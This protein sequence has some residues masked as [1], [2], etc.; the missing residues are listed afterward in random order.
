MLT[1][2]QI[3]ARDGKLTAS[4]VACLMTGDPEKIMA[5]WLEM[6]GERQP[7][8]LSAVWPVQLGVA[9]EALNLEWYERSV[10]RKLTRRGEVVVHPE[11][12]WACSTLD[13]FDGGLVGPVDAK[14][15]GGFEPRATVVARYVPQMFWQM[16][17]T[18]TKA[19]ALSIIE[20]AR[21]PA[22]E[23]VAWDADYSTEL[24]KRA[25]AF[26]A[27][28]WSLTPPV[29]LP[30]AAVPVKAERIVDMAGNNEFASHAAEW[31][32]T[33]DAAGKFEKAAKGLKALTPADAARCHG[34][35]VVVSRDKASRLT[36]REIA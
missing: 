5:L 13:G 31:K 16:D 28:V 27:C 7:D 3:A 36:I 34:Y 15:V 11:F 24:W 23:P 29:A 18:G 8:D 32:E 17:C 14:H 21:E 22:I 9:T 6:L 33:R 30:A 35:G 12:P 1:A 26:M 20:G 4:R 19:S 10:G 2:P 25:H